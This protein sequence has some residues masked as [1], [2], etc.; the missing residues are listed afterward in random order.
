MPTHRRKKRRKK[1]G[2]VTRVRRKIRRR[3][4]SRKW[5]TIVII[6]LI[7]FLLPAT[8][9][10]ISYIVDRY[11]R[12]DR[13][14][15]VSGDYNGID[16]S[17]YQGNIDWP[18]VAKDPKIQF[19]YIKATEGTRTVDKR[20][21]RNI[22]QARHQGIMVGSYHFF[23]ASKSAEEQFRFFKS[24]VDRTRQDLIPMVDVEEQGVKG[25]PPAELRANLQRF[26]DLVKAEYGRYP[27][28]Y[29]QH[30]IYRDYLDP[31]FANYYLWIARY[32]GSAPTYR[33]GR[34]NIWQYSE[35]G[36]VKGIKGHVDLNRFQNGM[37]LDKLKL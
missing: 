13:H 6:V 36:T 37:T 1:T 15:V 18:T 11:T 5:R 23:I 34:C 16:V 29:V 28:L 14:T 7:L 27:V 21:N 30:N 4:H 33:H 20:Y 17:H 12:P 2:P 24:H 8:Y 35:H 26:M 19:V 9:S 32:S 10:G 22:V 25:T 3:L 31:Q